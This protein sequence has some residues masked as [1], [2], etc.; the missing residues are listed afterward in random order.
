MWRTYSSSRTL[1][2]T[3][4]YRKI[5]ISVNDIF[6]QNSAFKNYHLA[7]CGKVLEVIGQKDPILLEL[8]SCRNSRRSRRN[9]ASGEGNRW[10]V[11]FLVHA[12]VSNFEYRYVFYDN[13]SGTLLLNRKLTRLFQSPSHQPEGYSCP[14]NYQ[15][16]GS[17]FAK[18]DSVS[19]EN[20]MYDKILPNVYLGNIPH[21]KALTHV[22]H[23]I[24]ASINIPAEIEFLKKE[25]VDFVMNLQT[26]EDIRTH[27]QD[28]DGINNMYKENQIATLWHPVVEKNLRKLIKG[29]RSAINELKTAL[30]NSKVKQRLHL[31]KSLH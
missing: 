14:S 11:T 1:V 10:V 17:V 27:N 25:N 26:Q 24:G 20:F 22:I 4:D 3:W 19:Y 15:I 21:R 5:R 8:K 30:D 29:C 23:P 28:P 13:A 12:T 31:R 9:N 16:I 18:H 6:A 2:D 7:L